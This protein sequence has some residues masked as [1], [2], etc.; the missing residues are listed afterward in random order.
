M[1]FHMLKCYGGRKRCVLGQK[2]QR[3]NYLAK[4]TGNT[5]VDRA[6]IERIELDF[7]NWLAR[8]SYA[9]DSG[10]SISEDNTAYDEAEVEAMRSEVW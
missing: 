8:I 5:G 1:L 2:R 7:D 4:L 9:G 6:I 3:E 10:L